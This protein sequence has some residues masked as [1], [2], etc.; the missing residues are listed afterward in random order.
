MKIPSDKSCNSLEL[1]RH[2]LDKG[3]YLILLWWCRTH[4]G[5]LYYVDKETYFCSN[6]LI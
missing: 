4:L 3:E 6:E 1:V 5:S 2:V